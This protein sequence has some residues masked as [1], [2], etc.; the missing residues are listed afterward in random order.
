[1]KF[2]LL[3]LA[4]VLH[5]SSL[6][7]TATACG[8]PGQAPC[9]VSPAS[10]A[11][12]GAEMAPLTDALFNNWMNG[13]WDPQK[14]G[15][16]WPSSTF[17]LSGVN[18]VHGFMVGEFTSSIGFAASFVYHAGA[19]MCC[20]LSGPF[21][22][23]DIND[24]GLVLGFTPLGGWFVDELADLHAD[25]QPESPRFTD[26]FRPGINEVFSAID[27]QNRILLTQPGQNYVLT[28]VPEPGSLGL[29]ILGL[30]A[31]L[32]FEPRLYRF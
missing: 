11:A 29:V 18:A 31:L 1:M 17:T 32:G 26:G 3:L 7:Y 19:L 8:G 5:A 28:P 4:P 13:N 24:N 9:A 6:L 21:Q 25:Y 14:F 27:D 16:A 12:T 22:I 2:T 10:H 30:V 15:T 23:R 20:T